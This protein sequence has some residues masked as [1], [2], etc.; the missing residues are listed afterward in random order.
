MK[1]R[2]RESERERAGEGQREGE[3]ESQADSALSAQSQM[4]GASSQTVR[5]HD[6]SQRLNQLSHPGAPVFY[7]SIKCFND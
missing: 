2:E 7:F 5:V 6:L 3:R 1:E 4:W